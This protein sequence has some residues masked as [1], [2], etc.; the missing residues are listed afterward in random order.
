MRRLT[1]Y[2]LAPCLVLV[3][4]VSARAGQPGPIGVLGDSYSDEYQFYPPDRASARNWVEIRSPVTV[5]GKRVGVPNVTPAPAVTG[6]AVIWPEVADA[7]VISSRP[8]GDQTGWKSTAWRG[9]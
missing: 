1:C 5:E 6:I 4:A 8:S 9:A 2:L 3:A 7:T